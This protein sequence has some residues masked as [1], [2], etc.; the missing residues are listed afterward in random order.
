MG[1][2]VIMVLLP[3]LDWYLMI[4]TEF[5]LVAGIG[6]F[7]ARYIDSLFPVLR[8]RWINAYTVFC[9]GTALVVCLT[10]P[11]FF[12]R[13]LPFGT[14]I[15]GAFLI[16][17][18]AAALVAAFRKTLHTPL[19][20]MELRLLLSGLLIY[21]TLSVIDIY[22]HGRGY[23]LFGLAISQAG[24]IA[25]LFLNILALARGFARTEQEL[26]LARESERRMEENNRVMAQLDQLKTSFWSNISHELKTPLAVMSG[27]AQLSAWQIADGSADDETIE[28][29]GIV[30]EEAG[31]L[32]RLAAGLRQTTEDRLPGEPVQE[33]IAAVISRT[34]VVFQ[35]ILMRRNNRLEIR[36]EEGLPPVEISSDGIHQVLLNLLSNANRHMRDGTVTIQCKKTAGGAVAVIISDNGS[37][38]DPA[39]LPHVFDRQVS[40]AHSSGIGLSICREIITAHGGEIGIEST[41]GRGTKVTFTLPAAK[42]G[43]TDAADHTSD[44]G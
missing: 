1:D 25:F 42:G 36:T 8:R 17:L 16:L 40:G 3:E 39:L 43:D 14:G 24:T 26:G 2:K 12:S 30:S 28:N 9:G 37:G 13:C 33:D 10:P 34:G 11:A 6:L 38:I 7:S 23:R 41:P 5:L 31:R 44:R 35:P 19:S 29:L 20:R 22:A 15:Y 18:L 21:V 32:A 4:R 27:Y